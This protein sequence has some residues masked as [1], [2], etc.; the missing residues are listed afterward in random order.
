MI[1]GLM[2]LDI[3]VG[4]DRDEAR[5]RALAELAKARYGGTPDWLQNVADRAVGVLERLIELYQRWG[6]QPG[7]GVSPGF[8]VAVVLLLAGIAV[9]VWRVGMPRWRR[10]EAVGSLDLDPTRSADDYRS[11]ADQHARAG[12]WRAAVRDRFRAV[13]RDLEVRTILDVR[14]ARTA[15][16]AA[17]AASRTLTSALDALNSGAETF[18]HVMYGEGV[19]DAEAYA[20]MVAVD[21]AVTAAADSTDLAAVP[22][23]VST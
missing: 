3:P 8:V 13:V 2:P 15:W 1:P 11:L 12:D 21:Q 14:P 17:Y 18:N 4:L 7:D 10:R 16:E 9:V 6:R 19:A 5:R 22:E 23:P 20:R